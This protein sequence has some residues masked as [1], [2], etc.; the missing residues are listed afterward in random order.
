MAHLISIMVFLIY[1]SLFL[2]MYA[3]YLNKAQKAQAKADRLKDFKDMNKD[4]VSK[5]TLK[6]YVNENMN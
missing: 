4:W 6:R 1:G 3:V 5:K 2:K